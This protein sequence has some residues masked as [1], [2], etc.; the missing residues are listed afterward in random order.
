MP[1]RDATYAAKNRYM[2]TG[3]PNVTTILEIE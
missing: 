2:L 1:E 3:K